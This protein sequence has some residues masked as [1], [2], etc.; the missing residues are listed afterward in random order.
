VVPRRRHFEPGHI[1][2]VLNRGTQRQQL[3][4]S[5][6]DYRRFEVLIEDT[7][8]RIPLRVL[9][10]EL[11]P[12]H[13]HFVVKPDDQDQLS[14]FFGYLAG[15]HGKRFRVA[16]GTTGQGHVYQDR[17]KSFPVQSDGHFLT[18]CRYVERNAL[19]AGLVGQAE[20]WPWGALWRRQHAL[21]SWLM[22]DWPVPRPH[23]W[24]DRVNASLTKAE[25]TAVKNSI[26]RGTPFGTSLW[27][28]ET[29]DQ[30]DL[31]HTL[32]R[33]GRPCIAAVGSS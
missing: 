20:A 23:D 21:D 6:D 2:H 17:F 33:C 32:R 11:M 7:L 10:F 5:N 3:F 19:R 9:T 13:W 16:H 26:R 27:V 4:F 28:R 14:S 8:A 25:M 1:Y 12:N 31:G 24:I 22:S 30:L 15:T 18:V 29:A